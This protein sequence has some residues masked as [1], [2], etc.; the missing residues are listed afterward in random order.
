MPI[1]EFYCDQCNTI[2]NFFARSVNTT[3][4]P[5]CPRC[6]TVTLSRRMS[7]FAVTGRAKEDGETDDLPFDASKMEQAME[8]LSGEAERINED[9]PRQ[10]ADLMRKLTRMTGMELGG[11]MEEALRR[12]ERGEDPEQIEAELGDVLENE[13]PFLMP[14]KKGAAGTRRAAP[15]RDETLYDL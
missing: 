12:M 13:D 8:M 10:A 6:E 14:G 4:R 1:Y 15:R 2:F 3:K 7:T 5:Q 11:G 9:D